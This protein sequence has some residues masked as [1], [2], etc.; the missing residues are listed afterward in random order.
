MQE[1]LFVIYYSCI[2]LSVIIG[3]RRYG[4]FDRA[5]RALVALLFVIAVCEFIA[6]I[7]YK[8]KH[9]TE[10]PVVYHFACI[11]RLILVTIYFIRLLKPSGTNKLIATILFLWPAIGLLNIAFLQPITALNTNMLMVESFSVITMSLYSI[12]WM[13]KSDQEVGV[14]IN[15]HF[16]ICII[17]CILFSSTFFFWAFIKILYKNHWTHMNTVLTL[18]VFINVLV[19]FG[20]ALVLFFYP[21]KIN[22]LENG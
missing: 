22:A 3:I 16:W 7:L 12:Y 13:I 1:V 9:Y 21:K 8:T 17:W 20:I 5:T 11:L 14:F 19:Y 18:Q 2:V 4:E 6:F 10:R 15:T